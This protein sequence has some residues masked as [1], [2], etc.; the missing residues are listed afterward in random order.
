MNRPYV[1]SRCSRLLL[2]TTG[3]LRNAGFVSL[4]KLVDRDN[5]SQ[6]QIQERPVSDVEVASVHRA[7]Q[8]TKRQS[9]FQQY[10][11]QNKPVGV[12]KVLETLFSSNRAHE[13]ASQVS[14]YSRTPKD[15]QAEHVTETTA[16]DKSIDRRLLELHN[17]LKR[18]TSSLEYI[19]TS[20]LQLLGERNWITER[21]SSGEARKNQNIAFRDVLLAICAKQQI[22]IQ[23]TIVTPRSVIQTY[24]IHGVMRSWWHLVLWTQLGELLK[25]RYTTAEKTVKE[26]KKAKSLARDHLKVWFLFTKTY[27]T[28]DLVS[29]NEDNEHLSISDQRKASKG[30]PHEALETRFQRLMDKHPD[31]P[32]VGSMAAAAILTSEY[33]NAERKTCDPPL[34]TF[35][36]QLRRD[37]EPD[38]SATKFWLSEARV[39][40]E[41][42]ELIPEDLRLQPPADKHFK[43][44]WRRDEFG[45]RKAETIYDWSEEGIHKRLVEIDVASRKSDPEDAVNL[46]E[47]Y[48]GYLGKNGS[49]DKDTNSRIHARF[50]RTFWALRF[51]DKAI[52]VWNHMVSSGQ[53]PAQMHWT[54]MLSGCVPARDVT[55]LQEI[56][57][58][59]LRSN[60]TPDI[61]TWTTYIHSLIKLWKYQEGLE[62]LEALGRAWKG[63][64]ATGIAKDRRIQQKDA[65][66]L[67][68]QLEPV[69][70]A[71]SALVD[72]KKHDLHPIV[73]AWAE[74]HGLR[75]TT[76]TFN[77]L[78]QPIVRHGTPAQVQSHLQ[79][80]ATHNCEPDII[81]Y[82][83]IFNGLVSNRN[84]FFHTLPPE[85][86]ESTI[87]SRLKD[88]EERGVPANART[89]SILLDALLNPKSW[90]EFK[91]ISDADT[92]KQTYNVPAART[93]LA[94][95]QSRSI[96]PSPHHYTILLSHY[97][98]YKPPD[99]AAVES[100]W[101]GIRHGGQ[102]EM[103]DE[104]FYDR[105][106]QG[107][108]N[109]DEI[110]KALQ[111]VR[112]VPEEGKKPTW[113]A[114][115]RILAALERG[116]EWD[117]CKDLMV[118][119]EDP[120]GLFRHGQGLFRGKRE[121]YEL[122][123]Q[124]RAEGVMMGGAEQI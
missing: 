30:H 4:G 27:Q 54:A 29:G 100:L 82:T 57:R 37:R 87:I 108:A 5:G 86:Q 91:Y 122:V 13:Q 18:G 110:E 123:D 103:M 97:F 113:W 116:R 25:L 63:K 65:S 39:D 35:F 109:N 12:D 16:D 121:F 117:L 53:P 98:N 89:Y 20:C 85:A 67:A 3:Q 107:Y 73:V 114:L 46:W 71:L 95:M 80:M 45:E 96:P 36:S 62:A 74:S 48:L 7:R 17:Q 58:N 6:T 105:I 34:A 8:K 61:E 78:L 23:G 99:F 31:G 33:L 10:Q 77:I 47:N 26:T 41:I 118:E 56:W 59:M 24:L 112:R 21:S 76:F 50:L 44:V 1:C 81:T 32:S 14:R 119:I 104:L 101:A 94:H 60:F 70:A 66:P 55:S 93:I 40:S 75:L 43:P 111:F 79:Q 42:V 124:L 28:P 19:W 22:S 11:E 115:Y 68:P 15:Q 9:Y 84:S 72:I 69:H 64:T 102:T 120:K 2:R 52:A 92:D 49:H 90:K 51:S 83:I 106:V 88:M 38:L